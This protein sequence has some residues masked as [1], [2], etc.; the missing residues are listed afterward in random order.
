[1]S[2]NSLRLAFAGNPELAAAILESLL[3][4]PRID[5]VAVITNPDKPAGRGR[6]S[7][8]N[9]VSLV[10]EAQG[11]V[12]LQPATTE[13]LSEMIKQLE[14]DV[15][16][17]V[18]FGMFLPVEIINYPRLGSINIH[19]SLLP[20]WR[21][22]APVQRAILAGDKETGI[23][24]MQMDEGLDT[25]D[26]LL[27]EKCKIGTRETAGGVIERLID[28][29]IRCLHKVLQ[30][31]GSDALLPIPQDKTKVTYARKL[32]KAE[33]RLDWSLPADELD[34]MVRAFNP[35]PIAYT[36]INAVSMRVLE[37]EPVYI[38]VQNFN[39]GDVISADKSGILVTAKNNALLL[40]R[41]QLPGKRPV[42]PVEFLNGHPDFL[43]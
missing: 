10:A 24:I 28:I 20:R 35:V 34:R 2:S 6:K 30:L 37:A 21:G 18:A 25:G 15:M 22:A 42:G 40:K 27:Q 43:K 23:T 4:I 29:S 12:L 7:K 31:L 14:L 19:T 32:S 41:I 16:V 5:V 9:A 33:A 17:V 8:K 39:P 1:M 3:N 26:I 38:D 11:L 13:Q 36:E